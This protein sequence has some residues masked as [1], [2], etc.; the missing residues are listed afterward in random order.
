LILAKKQLNPI[1]GGTQKCR[2]EIFDDEKSSLKSKHFNL[3]NM[4]NGTDFVGYTRT[5]L[6][7]SKGKSKK[8]DFYKETSFSEVALS[9]VNYSFFLTR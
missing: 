5:L 2:Y 4:E 8:T 1:Q 9:T 6:G 7:T 3:I